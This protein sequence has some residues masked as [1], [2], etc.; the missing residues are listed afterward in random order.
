M[1]ALRVILVAVVGNGKQVL[2]GAAF[3][4]LILAAPQL[5]VIGV[6]CQSAA[7]DHLVSIFHGLLQTA[8]RGGELRVLLAVG[9]GCH[10]VVRQGVVT[11]Y[12]IGAGQQALGS[13]LGRYAGVAVIIFEQALG[14]G[15]IA[16]HL[17][18]HLVD[19]STLG[20]AA[21]FFGKDRNLSPQ[22]CQLEVGQTAQELGLAHGGVVSGLRHLALIE[23][24]GDGGD[25]LVGL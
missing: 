6:E 23:R 4:A 25:G 18:E 12:E 19:G 2:V 14:I 10:L 3:V 13:L 8:R 7:V 9:D 24:V 17:I 11:P 22:L 21:T 20:M 1:I 5:A 16:H 15:E